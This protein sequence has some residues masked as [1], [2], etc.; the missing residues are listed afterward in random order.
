MFRLYL[1]QLWFSYTGTWSW[2][3]NKFLQL[4][5]ITVDTLF[6]ME[7]IAIFVREKRP[8]VPVCCWLPSRTGYQNHI[9]YIIDIMWQGMKSAGYQTE[10]QFANK[11]KTN[12]SCHQQT[13]RGLQCANHVCI[14]WFNETVLSLTIQHF[15]LLTKVS[16]HEARLIILTEHWLL[17]T[18]YLGTKT[19]NLP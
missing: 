9:F 12:N 2:L 3:R 4:K 14:P 13:Y 11:L 17:F 18:F 19:D 1:S 7:S 10:V 5:L 6:L 8:M 16:N 15:H